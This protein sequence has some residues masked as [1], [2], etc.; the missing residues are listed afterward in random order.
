MPS[1]GTKKS[2]RK[3]LISKLDRAFSI[4]IRSRAADRKGMGRCFTCDKRMHWRKLQCG[5]FMSRQYYAQRW[6]PLNAYPQC[7]ACNLRSGEQYEM[8]K[9]MNWMHGE[10]TAE[11][12][13]MAAKKPTRMKDAQ[14][15]EMLDEYTAK[16]QQTCQRFH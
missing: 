6:S 15:N 12:V 16:A 13:T 3:T 10:G 9:R 14:L 4:Y 2:T 8:G 11:A 5:H 7:R 1:R